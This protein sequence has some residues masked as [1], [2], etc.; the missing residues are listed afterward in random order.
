[1]K[2]KNKRA[3][4]RALKIHNRNRAKTFSLWNE[5]GYTKP[6]LSRQVYERKAKRS[7]NHKIISEQSIR[8]QNKNINIVRLD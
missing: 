6:C 5:R 3:Y 7:F 8:E 1:M 4:Y 2:I